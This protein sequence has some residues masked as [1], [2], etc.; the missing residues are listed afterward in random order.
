MDYKYRRFCRNVHKIHDEFKSIMESNEL[1]T[2]YVK[3]II[4]DI[5]RGNFSKA[6]NIILA[7]SDRLIDTP[8]GDILRKYKVYENFG[9]F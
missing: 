9:W 6:F 4:L 1:C 3:Y 2:T 7:E 5:E 8:F